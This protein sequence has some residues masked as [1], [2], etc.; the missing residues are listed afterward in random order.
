[1]YC[2]KMP[3]D[4]ITHYYRMHD[5]HSLLLQRT[6]ALLVESLSRGGAAVEPP[7]LHPAI[8][9]YAVSRRAAAARMWCARQKTS[10]LEFLPEGIAQAQL[11]LDF[12]RRSPISV[13]ARPPNICTIV[14]YWIGWASFIVIR[15]AL[16]QAPPQ[17]EGH[18]ITRP[19]SRVHPSPCCQ[20]IFIAEMRQQT[21]FHHVHGWE[22]L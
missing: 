10:S 13:G 4:R 3:P 14:L 2:S 11:S 7:D 8:F 15:S 20:G 16:P 12:P 6:H 1:M 19:C 18:S 21:S 17:G 5:L 9:V 22:S